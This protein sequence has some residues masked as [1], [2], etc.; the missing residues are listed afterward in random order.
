[1]LPELLEGASSLWQG[2][3]EIAALTFGIGIM[4]LIAEYE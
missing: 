4:V 2:V 1:V 3:K